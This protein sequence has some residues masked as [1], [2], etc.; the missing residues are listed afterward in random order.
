MSELERSEKRYFPLWPVL[1]LLLPPCVFSQQSE[2]DGVEKRS[3]GD[4]VSELDSHSPC[5]ASSV[6]SS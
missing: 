6:L 4:G 1:R 3:N 5:G 2:K